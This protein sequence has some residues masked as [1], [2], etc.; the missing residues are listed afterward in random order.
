M[1]PP[2]V[3]E[4]RA[5]IEGTLATHPW[6]VDEREGRVAG[7]AYASTHRSREAYQWS[8]DVS[9]YVHPG[10]HR[11]GIGA[12]LYRVLLKVLRR[13]GFQSAYA[14]IA[15]PNPASVR[16]HESVGFTPVGVYRQSGYKLGAWRDTGWWQCSLGE[17][18]A[19]P[20]PPVPLARL[21]PR[22]LDDL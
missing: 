10:A 18:A 3:E 8:V 15:L 4:M 19:N 17:A 7:Y 1:Q 6:L 21:G 9:C 12:A 2:T 20:A 11:Q 16:L 5:R 13:Q 14:G 22:V